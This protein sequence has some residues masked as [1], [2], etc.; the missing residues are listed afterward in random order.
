M[1]PDASKRRKIKAF[2]PEL[3]WIT[4]AD[5]KSFALALEVDKNPKSK[6]YNQELLIAQSVKVTINGVK[7]IFDLA[8]LVLDH[9]RRLA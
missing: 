2:P 6:Q 7:R 5:R 1:D 8:G 3:E 9:L 4:D